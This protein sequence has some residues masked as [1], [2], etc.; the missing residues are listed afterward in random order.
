MRARLRSM[1]LL[2][3]GI[4]HSNSTSGFGRRFR[5]DDLHAVSGGLDIADIHQARQRGG[6]EPCNRPAAGVQRQ[7][8]AVRLSN[9]RGDITQVYLSSKSRFCGLGIVV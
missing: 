4:F 5:Q 2:H 9:Q 7:M 6:P 8:I 3:F 1:A